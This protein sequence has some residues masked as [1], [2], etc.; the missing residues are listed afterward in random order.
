MYQVHRCVYSLP[1]PQA[2]SALCLREQSSRPEALPC[3]LSHVYYCR[4]LKRKKKSDQMQLR[5]ERDYLAYAH[6]Y[7]SSLKWEQEPG[8]RSW[9]R[10]HG[11]VLLTGSTVAYSAC[12]P[13]IPRIRTSWEAPP[14]TASWSLPYQASI[15]EMHHRTI[16]WDIFSVGVPLLKWLRHVWNWHKSSQH[17][18]YIKCWV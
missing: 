7:S 1:N 10:G 8:G 16:S 3:C 4:D 12:F 18:T 11:E 2:L 17:N 9:S 15:K 14:P 6:H 5:E 13:I